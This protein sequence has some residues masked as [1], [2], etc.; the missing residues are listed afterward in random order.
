M[1]ECTNSLVFL[2]KKYT[3]NKKVYAK[4]LEKFSVYIRSLVFLANKCT[5]NKKLKAKIYGK[6][7]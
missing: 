6:C 1:S 4:S 3:M 5:M 2:G 7:S